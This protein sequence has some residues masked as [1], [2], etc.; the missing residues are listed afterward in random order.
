[1]LYCLSECWMSWNAAKRA[2]GFGHRAVLWYADG[3]DGWEAAGL[4]TEVLRPAPG[5]P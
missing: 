1:M 4:P 2:A 3:A 5:A